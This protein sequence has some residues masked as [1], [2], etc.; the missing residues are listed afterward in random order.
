MFQ[1]YNLINYLTVFENVALALKISGIKN[2]KEIKTRVE[3]ILNALG[4]YK[5]R[6]RLASMLS[7]GEKQRVAIARALVKNP[8]IIIADEPTGNLDSKNSLEIMNI[9]KAISKDKLVI[10]VTH[11]R[12]LAQFYASRIIEIVDGKI[13][14]DRNNEQADDLDYR[15]E[16]K[17]YLK[18][19]ESCEKIEKGKFNIDIYS[20]TKE[21]E[22]KINVK[23]VLK[24]GNLYIESNNKTE[25]ID[26]NSSIELVDGHYKKLSKEEAD[27]YKFDYEKIIN[28]KYKTKYTSIYNPITLLI[29]GF[30]RVLDYSIL[31]KLLL[32][33]FIA[34]SMFILYGV[35]N[36]FGTLD[37]KDEEFVSKNANYLD[38]TMP[39]IDI[40][41]YLKYENLEHVQ[42]IIPGNSQIQFYMKYED[43]YQTKDAQDTYSASLSS[44]ELINSNN[45]IYGR[46]P[47]DE[48]EV[49]LD[50][51]VIDKI[52]CEYYSNAK[53]AGILN[54][55]AYLNRYIKLRSS[56]PKYN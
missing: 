31:K 37:I 53:Q 7:G 23:L 9:I 6:N 42:Y 40:S 21:N 19:L 27:K 1:N 43:Y 51:M 14:N 54:I 39:N 28:K 8:N 4:I 49:V 18:D 3:Y 47:E 12:N 35:S 55:E 24:N 34:S 30:K 56:I 32:L 46:M 11:E 52:L 26:D 45:L 36:I 33:G 48:Y 5:Y 17:I 13:V 15:L 25:L 29:A 2:K 22:S 41:K 10:L 38:I 44:I 20:D 50:K 16:S